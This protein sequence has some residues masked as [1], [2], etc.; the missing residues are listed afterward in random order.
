MKSVGD[1][2]R[3]SRERDRMFSEEDKG[4]GLGF[5]LGIFAAGLVLFLWLAHR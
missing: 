2:R 3:E 4:F 5:V 1:I